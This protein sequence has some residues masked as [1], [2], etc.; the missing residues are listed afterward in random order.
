MQKKNKAQK[1]NKKS[2]KNLAHQTGAQAVCE[3]PGSS[4]RPKPMTKGIR[5]DLGR[6]REA[7]ESSKSSGKYH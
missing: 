1:A 7:Q 4:G 3:A 2:T 5:E 6:L